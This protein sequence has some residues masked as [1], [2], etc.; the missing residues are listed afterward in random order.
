LVPDQTWR[1]ARARG[2]RREHAD[3]SP[4]DR[5]VRIEEAPRADE[6]RRHGVEPVEPQD[7]EVGQG[8]FPL[9]LLDLQDAVEPAMHVHFDRAA[10]GES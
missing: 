8:E 7:V 3:R 6:G 1:E 10:A 4:L 9:V 2:E 5:E